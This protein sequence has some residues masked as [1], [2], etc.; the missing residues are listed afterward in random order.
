MRLEELCSLILVYD[1]CKAIPRVPSHS[2]ENDLRGGLAN[3]EWTSKC[4]CHCY[5]FYLFTRI[6]SGNCR[7]WREMMPH[8]WDF[9]EFNI[10]IYCGAVWICDIT[11]SSTEYFVEFCSDYNMLH[12]HLNPVARN[13]P[14]S[15]IR[16][17]N[18]KRQTKKQFEANDLLKTIIILS[19]ELCRLT[20]WQRVRRAGTSSTWQL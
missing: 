2:Y 12:I 5:D 18:G 10:K 1:D 4:V 6:F 9:H 20:R 15:A 14:L 8:P 19:Q 11:T 13:V 17:C 7:Q 16:L 3:F